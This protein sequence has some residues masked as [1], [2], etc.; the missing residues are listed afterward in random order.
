MNKTKHQNNFACDSF[1]RHQRRGYCRENGPLLL[2]GQGGERIIEGIKEIIPNKAVVR[3]TW[4]RGGGRGGGKGGGGAREGRWE[5]I[6][7]KM[8]MKEKDLS[9]FLFPLISCTNVA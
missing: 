1:V 4:K 8:I 9:Q 6:G 2:C 5:G 3:R 7:L